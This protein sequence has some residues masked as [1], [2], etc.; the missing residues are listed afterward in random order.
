MHIKNYIPGDEHAILE[1]FELVFGK[2][3]TLAYWQWRFQH[4]PVGKMMIKLMWDNEK[5]V[6]HYAVSP[7]VID[8]NGEKRLTGLSMTTMTHPEYT[9]LG[10]FQQLSESLYTEVQAAHDVAAIWGFPNNNSHRGFIKNLGWK[11]LTVLP[12]LS[13]RIN[14]VNARQHADIRPFDRFTAREADCYEECSRE[15]RF[16]VSKD[17]AYL[18]WRYMDNPSNKYL[19]FRFE[20]DQPGFVVCKEYQAG[21]EK[22]VDIVEWCVPNDEKSSRAMLQHLATVFPAENYGNINTWMPLVDERH[23]HLEKLGFI[24]TVPVTYWGVCPFK[25]ERLD[26]QAGWWIQ[27]GDSDVY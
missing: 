26:E 27:L 2:P 5:L 17:E 24:N 19:A 20:N 8:S 18:N 12:M 9:G 21:N 3:M 16:K 13:C 11:D 1:L 25:E 23:L 22:Q 4:N 6:G 7:V 10:I 14:V 15:Y